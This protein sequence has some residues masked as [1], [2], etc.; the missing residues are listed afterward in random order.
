MLRLQPAVVLTP[1]RSLRRVE[2]MLGR[3]VESRSRT[4]LLALLMGGDTQKGPSH[5]WLI[6]GVAGCEDSAEIWSPAAAPA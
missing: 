6:A 5:S 4:R 3:V 1:K 2:S